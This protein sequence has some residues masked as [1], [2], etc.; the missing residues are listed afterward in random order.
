MAVSVMSGSIIEGCMYKLVT[1]VKKKKNFISLLYHCYCN[2]YYRPLCWR[3]LYNSFQTSG[4][5]HP[6]PVALTP[7]P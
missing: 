2:V 5:P 6:V 7:R 1:I 3:A 4:Y